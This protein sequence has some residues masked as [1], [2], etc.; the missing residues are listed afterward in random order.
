[1]VE[2]LDPTCQNAD[3]QQNAD[4]HC[5]F[6]SGESWFGLS[7]V[8]VR[9]V[10]SR[11]KIFAVPHSHE[12]LGGIC[13]LRNEFLPALHLQALLGDEVPQFTRAGQMLVLTSAGESWALLI[14]RAVAIESLD[15]SINP[16]VKLD[17]GLSAALLG[18]A[19]YGEHV[20]RV[21]DPN[22][23]YRLAEDSL[24]SRWLNEV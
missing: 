13:H 18:T 23:L 5:V 17:D 4:K 2:V 24:R 7:A 10:T 21:L 8:S 22:S 16:D 20:V 11:Q 12:A 9:E 3:R 6:L 15:L 14:D 19:A 1:M